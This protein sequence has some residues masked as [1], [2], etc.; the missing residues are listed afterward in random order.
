MSLV[1]ASAFVQKLPPYTAARFLTGKTPSRFVAE[2]EEEDDEEE[3]DE[4]SK[5]KVYLCFKGV[6]V[7]PQPA[8]M[9][10]ACSQL[11]CF[12]LG[13]VHSALHLPAVLV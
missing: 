10:C 9:S 13:S 11:Y 3:E 6:T 12:R 1:L 7:C 2:E 4:E 5:S 8:V